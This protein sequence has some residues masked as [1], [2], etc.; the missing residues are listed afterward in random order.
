MGSSGTL[1]VNDE[2]K[3]LSLRD[4]ALRLV[5]LDQQVIRA[6][7]GC[8]IEEFGRGLYAYE[9]LRRS[10]K[11]QLLDAST[12]SVGDAEAAEILRKIADGDGLRTDEVIRQLV[13]SRDGEPTIE[14]FD[15]VEIEEL[16]STLFYSWYSH[17]EYLS[18]LA[19]LRPLILKCNTSESVKRLVRQVKECYAFQQYDAAFGLCRTLL[20]ASIRDICARRH[21]FPALSESAIR[22]ETLRWRKMRNAVSYGQLNEKLEALYERLCVVL[23]ARSAANAKDARE[24]FRETLLL[25]EELYEFHKL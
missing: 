8:D 15:D 14:D 17:H 18:A 19:E 16:S 3:A 21:L 25:I 11:I 7:I 23:H 20:E 13:K 22:H 10:V 24:S 12:I 2:P 4:N 9:E 5:E 1:V 6:L